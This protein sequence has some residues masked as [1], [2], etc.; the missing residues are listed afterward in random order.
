MAIDNGKIIT[1]DHTIV[2]LHGMIHHLEHIM[3]DHYTLCHHQESPIL[4]PRD[5]AYEIQD[6][7]S[8][9]TSNRKSRNSFKSDG[10]RTHC[11]KS[12]KTINK[13]RTLDSSKSDTNHNRPPITMG[14]TL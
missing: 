12:T 8:G 9:T 13:K 4:S 2:L 7:V 3:L 11:H 10:N 5:V 14:N 1:T 6:D